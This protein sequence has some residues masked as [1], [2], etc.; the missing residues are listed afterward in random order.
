MTKATKLTRPPVQTKPVKCRICGDDIMFPYA[1]YEN[2]GGDDWICRRTCDE[3]YQDLREQ[4]W[5]AAQN[6]P[7]T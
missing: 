3:A 2:E 1:R 5:K 6:A 4:A 7:K